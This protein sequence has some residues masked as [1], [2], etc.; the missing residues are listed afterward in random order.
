MTAINPPL[1]VILNINGLTTPIKGRDQEN[2]FFNVDLFA[3][4]HFRF[5]DIIFKIKVYTI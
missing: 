3:I 2:I 4:R 5:K 1:S